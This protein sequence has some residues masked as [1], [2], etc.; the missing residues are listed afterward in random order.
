MKK[1]RWFFLCAVFLR[2]LLCCTACG[3][4]TQR[5]SDSTANTTHS[6]TDFARSDSGEE[7]LP[8]PEEKNGIAVKIGEYEFEATLAD[9]VAAE[10]FAAT[11]EEGPVTI[12]MSDYGGFEKVGPLN[13]SLPADDRYITTGAGDIVLYN[14]NQIV[15]FYGSNSWSYTPIAKVADLTGWQEALAGGSVAVTFYKE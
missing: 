14:K 12:E 3:G 1:I 5:N 7:N 11:L 15:M 6:S 8:A 4:Q 10:A 9:S 13:D 2:A